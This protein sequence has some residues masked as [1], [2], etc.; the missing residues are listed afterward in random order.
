MP[1]FFVHLH[2]NLFRASPLFLLVFICRCCYEVFFTSRDIVVTYNQY[3]D[4]VGFRYSLETSNVASD[5][6][7][8]KDTTG[9]VITVEQKY[10]KVADMSS[11]TVDFETDNKNLRAIIAGNDAVIQM[12]NFNGLKGDRSLVMT[13]GVMPDNFDILVEQIQQIGAIKSFNVTKVDKTGEYRSLIAQ[14][15]TLKKTRDSYIDIKE[16]A[17]EIKDLLMLEE[18][19]LDVEAKLQDLGVDIGIFS[20][21]YSF[22]TINFNLLEATKHTISVRF[23]LGCAKSSLSWTLT[24]FAVTLFVVAAA[25]FALWIILL[26]INNIKLPPKANDAGADMP[27][28]R[29]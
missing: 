5:K 26:L 3:L 4:D 16:M 29:E 10:E 9:S 14:Q 19:I 25:L 17:G 23:V 20:T 28:N 27:E 2:Q 8:Q 21:E 15:E 12:E 7:I 22:C 11:S 13:I 1:F 18:K 6:I 24:V